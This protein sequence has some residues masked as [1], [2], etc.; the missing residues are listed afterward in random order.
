MALITCEGIVL[1]THALGDTSRIV[2]VYTRDHGL[3]KFVAKGARKLPSRFG[4]A[5]E[6]LSRSRFVF[7]LKPDRD[8]HLLSKAEV[9]DAMGSRL[10]D[11]S[12]L[13]HA[14]ASLEIVDRL[15]W[16]E[17]PHP[18]LFALLVQALEGCTRAPVATLPAVT[19]AFQL[20]L[21]AELGYRP[22]LDQCAIDGRAVSQRRAFSPSRGGLLCDSCAAREGGVV[23][24]SAEALA[25]LALL[26]SRPVL[27]AGDYIEL[28]RAGE[29]MR[30][31]E[32]FFRTHFQR[33]VGLRALD[34]LRGLDG[35]GAIPRA[36]EPRVAL[37]AYVV[38][39]EALVPGVADAPRVP[40]EA[41]AADAAAR[42]L[43]ALSVQRA[44]AAEAA[45]AAPAPPA[46]E[47]EPP[48]TGRT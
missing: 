44:A 35:P 7:Y 19:L 6:P 11:L 47:H 46:A 26:L 36:S 24:L 22:R 16:G 27:E 31:I 39:P 9:L 42:A 12:R 13:A 23:F 40:T 20:Q 37:P 5:L 30:V 4:Y 2:T 28:P 10:S 48:A 17:E 8:L 32:D 41:D 29:L 18:K 3:R 33:F 14:Q 1:K 21:A 43:A 38:P 45:A 34:V 15:V 25:S